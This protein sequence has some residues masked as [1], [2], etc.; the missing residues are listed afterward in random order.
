MEYDNLVEDDC[1]KETEGNDKN[2]VEGHKTEGTTHCEK[3]NSASTVNE[4]TKA[5]A[6][7]ANV[8]EVQESD[9][10]QLKLSMLKNE[11]SIKPHIKPRG[12]PNNRGVIW[13]YK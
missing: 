1:V 8:K 5:E 4:I 3:Q 12:R 2:I 11:M 9:I 7:V 6:N 13:P 10:K